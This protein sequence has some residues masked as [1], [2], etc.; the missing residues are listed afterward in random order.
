MGQIGV[1]TLSHLH[2]RLR[3][4]PPSTGFRRRGQAA[5][6]E[7]L[8]GWC[9]GHHPIRLNLQLLQSR[10]VAQSHHGDLL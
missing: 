8:I 5:D 10:L 4:V 3:V 2:A 7:K 1:V 9:E 6:S